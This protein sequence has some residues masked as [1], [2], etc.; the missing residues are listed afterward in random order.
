M[1]TKSI[2]FLTDSL[3]IPTE[4]TLKCLSS[5]IEVYMNLD[6][7]PKIAGRFYFLYSMQCNVWNSLL[8]FEKE[9]S[10]LFGMESALF[11]SS[12]TMGNL[13]CSKE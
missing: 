10:D 5:P 12:G 4:E 8:A 6:Q 9:C 3:S 11:V 1:D 7:D 13:L 2:N